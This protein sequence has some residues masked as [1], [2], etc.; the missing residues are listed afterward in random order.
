M[1]LKQLV[2]NALPTDSKLLQAQIQELNILNK[3]A[4]ALNSKTLEPETIQQINNF[5]KL[6]SDQ[7]KSKTIQLQQSQQQAQTQQQAKQQVAT[8]QKA[9]TAAPQAASMQ[10]NGL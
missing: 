3:N 4:S 10:A 8:Q 6:V 5:K 9:Q 7:L 1:T 2:E